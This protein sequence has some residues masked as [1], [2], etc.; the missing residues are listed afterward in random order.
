MPYTIDEKMLKFGELMMDELGLYADPSGLV[1]DQE[2][3]APVSI[4]GKQLVYPANPEVTINKRSDMLFDP[5]SNPSLSKH[6][7]GF[8]AEHR[9]D[10]DIESFYGMPGVDIKDKGIIRV[11]SN[12]KVIAESGNY[13]NDSVRYC[14]LIM[15]MNGDDN[16]DLEIFDSMIDKKR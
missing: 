9:S 8:Y 12:D 1:C 10:E 3:D 6:L 7:F 14:D 2:T 16:P 11:Q 13:Y 15:R 4:N 5:L